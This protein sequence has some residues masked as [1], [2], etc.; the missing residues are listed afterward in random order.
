MKTTL[1]YFT[2]TGNCLDVARN[3]QKTV[4]DTDLLSIPPLVRQTSIVPETNCIGL[5][6]PVYDYGV[7]LV[8]R[9][10]LDKLDVTNVA[11]VFAVITCNFLPGLA[12][13]RVD[14]LLKKKGKKL[15]SGFIIRMPGNY[16]VM[17][18]A[19]PGWM[20]R[21]KFNRGKK[22]VIKIAE[23]VNNRKDYG[24]EK[25]RAFIDRVLAPKM[26]KYIAEFN[27]RDE[28]FWIDERC[29]GC[30]ICQKVC[31]FD[32]IRIVDGKPQWQHQCQQCF[33]C[34]HLCPKA[35]VQI[36]KSTEKKKRYRNPSVTLQD[37]IKSSG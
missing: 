33:G 24:V 23:F 32:N 34:I 26:E 21:Y 4:G 17:Y 6:F 30:G 31:A 29:N 13:E 35:A 16:I 5:V 37:I 36:G 2:A 10:F 20:Q 7:P 11:Y 1:Y 25:S 18:G 3:I 28:K 8:V 22:K 14:E 27:T 9:E 12:L 15:N 19:N